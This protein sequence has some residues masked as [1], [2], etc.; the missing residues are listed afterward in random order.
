[1]PSVEL[2]RETACH[3]TGAASRAPED[4]VPAAKSDTGSPHSIRPL[5]RLHR[6]PSGPQP[7]TR[8]GA[9][10]SF[11]DGH[12]DLVRLS[13]SQKKKKNRSTA[14]MLA[15]LCLKD[16]SRD[17]RVEFAVHNGP[18]S[19]ILARFRAHRD[20]NGKASVVAAGR[21]GDME[22]GRRA[23]T[24]CCTFVLGAM[25]ADWHLDHRPVLWPIQTCSIFSRL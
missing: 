12:R 5:A 23:M 25:G 10:G 20:H 14:R 18:D 21:G 8:A 3:S 9:Q 13:F 2:T 16:I 7:C 6:N 17:V 1:M 11:P 24:T 19:V 22:S 15:V 4:T